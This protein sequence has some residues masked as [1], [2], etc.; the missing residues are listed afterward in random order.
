M[1]GWRLAIAG[2][3]AAILLWLMRTPATPRL[4]HAAPRTHSLPTPLGSAFDAAQVGSLVG[5][6]TWTGPK[7]LIDPIVVPVGAGVPTDPASVPNPNAIDGTG[8]GLADAIVWLR[9]VDLSR[10]KPWDHAKVAV[11]SVHPMLVVRQGQRVG[12]IGLV[13]RGS[14]IELVARNPRIHSVRGRGAAFFTQMLPDPHRPVSRRLSDSG[15]VEL[16]SGSGL[17]WLRAYLLVSEHPYVAVTGPDGRFRFDQVP[18]GDYELVCWRASWH[19]DRLER[20]PELVVPVRLHYHSAVERS[21]PIRIAP[22]TTTEIAFALSAG[23]F[24]PAK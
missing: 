2:V 13:Q 15:I 6:V 10:S 5:R 23:D 18:E 24:D 7:P 11:E 20:D 16:T 17:F 19:V 4:E 9:E 8:G 14:D 3:A 21:R 22:G 12:R 1:R